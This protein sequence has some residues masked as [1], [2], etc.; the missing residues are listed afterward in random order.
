MH[1]CTINSNQFYGKRLSVGL[2]VTFY[3][4]KDYLLETKKQSFTKSKI[5]I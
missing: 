3:N 2:L 1:V 5:I 4:I